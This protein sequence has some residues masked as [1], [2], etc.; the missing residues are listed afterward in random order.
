MRGAKNIKYVHYTLGAKWTM[1]V[2]FVLRISQF[3]PA[4]LVVLD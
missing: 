2:I 4:L 3:S 1:A